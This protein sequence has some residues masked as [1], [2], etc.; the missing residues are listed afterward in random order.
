LRVGSEQRDPLDERL[1]EQ[2][3]VEWILVQRRKAIDVDGVLAGDRKLR[4]A[5]IQER[6]TQ[7]A[8]LDAEI[9]AAEGGLDRDLP[10]ARGAEKKFVG[11]IVEVPLRAGGEALRLTCGPE[12]E[13]CRGAA[14]PAD[15]EERRDLPLAHTIEV[16]RYFDLALEKA[17]TAGLGRRVQSR[18]LH[19]RLPGFCNHE[20]LSACS[21]VDQSGELALRFIDV[22]GVHGVRIERS[23]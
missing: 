13:L 12:E 10:Q 6:A 3:P 1:R 7:D 9:I 20:G 21:A 8:R 15:S 11:R 17:E 14:S 23:C 22:D 2:K 18:Y 19:E 16:V 4:V 5:V